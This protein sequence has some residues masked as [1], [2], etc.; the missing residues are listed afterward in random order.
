MK[1]RSAGWKVYPPGTRVMFGSDESPNIGEIHSVTAY[2]DCVRYTVCAW[3]RG[4]Q[5]R[6]EMSEQ[7]FAV[8]P[9]T[10]RTFMGFQGPEDEDD[11]GE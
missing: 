4:G 6:Y 1:A 7:E 9:G 2:V 10:E 8:R 5:E 3:F 11:D